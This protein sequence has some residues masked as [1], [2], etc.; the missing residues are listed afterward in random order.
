V[1]VLSQLAWA[2]PVALVI[3]AAGVVAWLTRDYYSEPTLLDAP[4]RAGQKQPDAR[5]GA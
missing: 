5:D 4:H 2:L 3:V 1:S